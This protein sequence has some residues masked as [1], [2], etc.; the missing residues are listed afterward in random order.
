MSNSVNELRPAALR[1]CKANEGLSVG[2]RFST[3][4][5]TESFGLICPGFTITSLLKSKLETHNGE[6]R[7]ILQV[8]PLSSSQGASTL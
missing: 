5:H 2:T 8:Q 3:L 6:V 1:P 4:H 7:I